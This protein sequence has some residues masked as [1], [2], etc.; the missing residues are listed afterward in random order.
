MSLSDQSRQSLSGEY[1]P[2]SS[3]I[4]VAVQNCQLPP[5]K[6]LVRRNTKLLTH[7]VVHYYIYAM[8]REISV[9]LADWEYDPEHP[10][11]MINAADGRLILQVRRPLGIEQFELI[12]RPDGKRP[13][14]YASALD[15]V[16]DRLRSYTEEKGS[17]DGFELD[18]GEVQELRDEGI[19]FYYR[20]IVLFQMNQF[21]RVI[22]DTEHNIRLC[23]LLRRYCTAEDERNSVLQFEP[24][25]IRMHATAR[26]MTQVEAERIDVAETVITNAIERIEGLEHIESPAFQFERVRSVNYLRS[27]MEQV[28]RRNPNPLE[29]LKRELELAVEQEDYER[30][31]EIRDRIRDLSS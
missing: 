28:H 22:D 21:T 27:V 25:I 19:L 16:E 15:A 26:A 14:G 23:D 24:Y 9:L 18:P 2:H 7:V 1:G 6:T 12:G 31:A 10:T 29:D 13:G 8:D 20:Y 17:D 11:R 5:H 3:G 4:Q 30:A